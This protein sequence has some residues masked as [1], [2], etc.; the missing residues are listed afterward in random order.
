[1]SPLSLTVRCLALPLRL[2]TT[3]TASKPSARKSPPLSGS[4]GGRSDPVPQRDKSKTSR[5]HR[6][7]RPIT[8]RYIWVLDQNG[9]K[10]SN[11]CS[12]GSGGQCPWFGF[13]SLQWP[14][15]QMAREAIVGTADNGLW[16]SLIKNP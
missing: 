15:S 1:M 4:P 11:N 5:D 16:I 2:S 12:I 10:G 8:F 14:V 7:T 9:P 3:T 13:G 6:D